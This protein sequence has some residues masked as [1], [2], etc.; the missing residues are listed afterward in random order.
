[1]HAETRLTS[2]YDLFFSLSPHRKFV[3]RES[4]GPLEPTGLQLAG[5]AR[6]HPDWILSSP[7]LG[8]GND[9]RRFR[10]WDCG[11]TDPE[12][13]HGTGQGL[14]LHQHQANQITVSMHG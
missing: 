7:G 8:C 5:A 11:G 3:W 10:Q 1:M 13:G 4:G 12:H 2:L 9:A 6:L 14:P